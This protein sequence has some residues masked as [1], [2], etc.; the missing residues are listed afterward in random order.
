MGPRGVGEVGIPGSDFVSCPSPLPSS[1]S[2]RKPGTEL[3]GRR[4]TVGEGTAE[5]HVSV[6][7][8]AGLAQVGPSHR[9]QVF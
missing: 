4:L 2:C 6:L 8:P 5:S 7:S 1:L 9:F 3:A